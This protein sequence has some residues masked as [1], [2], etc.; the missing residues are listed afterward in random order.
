MVL[1]DGRVRIDEGWGFNPQFL[2]SFHCDPQPLT[3]CC[4]ADPPSSFSTIRT[5]PDFCS[6]TT[7]IS[8]LTNSHGKLFP[9]LQFPWL[10]WRHRCNGDH[11]SLCC[12]PAFFHL[13]VHP[14]CSILLTRNPSCQLCP[15]KSL[16]RL[17][18]KYSL[19]SNCCPPFFET[20]PHHPSY[21]TCIGR[22]GSMAKTKWKYGRVGW[23]KI[24]WNR[25]EI[26]QI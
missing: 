20:T 7:N 19:V 11:A 8:F 26:L 17:K 15:S 21:G 16:A 25:S 12:S 23:K 2:C 9:L 3:S 6:K 1:P 13:L 24:I 22:V 5:L 4:A 14:W 10:S 18:P